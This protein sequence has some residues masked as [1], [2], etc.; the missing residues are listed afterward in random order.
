M[1]KL[2]KKTNE[3]DDEDWSIGYATFV[4][5]GKDGSKICVRCKIDGLESEDQAM[6]DTG[7]TYTV[8]GRDVVQTIE[9]KLEDCGK[10]NIESCYG[11]ISGK[12]VKLNMTLIS[13][14]GCDL[15]IKSG[16]ALVSEDWDGRT[17]V[18]GYRGFLDKIRIAI[19]PGN[20]P[21]K[22]VFYFGTCE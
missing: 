17:I 20:N 3:K 9:H 4:E 5:G 22:Q 1:R 19:D 13:E 8:I 2:V 14:G 16:L 15:D 10:G 12:L 7:S 18:L 21:E 6:L 11:P